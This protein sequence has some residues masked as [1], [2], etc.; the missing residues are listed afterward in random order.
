MREEPDVMLSRREFKQKKKMREREHD[1]FELNNSLNNL[2]I[3]F[4][5]NNN[6]S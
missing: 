4:K 2:N 1:L 5:Q 6:Q 3:G